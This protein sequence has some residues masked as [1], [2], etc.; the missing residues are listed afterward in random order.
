MKK[1][2]DWERKWEARWIWTR[3]DHRASQPRPF[4]L[5]AAPPLPDRVA[6]LRR[7]FVLERVPV[8]VPCRITS[9]GRYE[10]FVNG[11][12]V[13]RG[14]VRGEPVHLR[15]DE[16]DLAPHLH[17]GDNVIGVV[18]RNYGVP[19]QY[20]RRPQ[21]VGDLGGGGL[22]AEVALEDDLVRTDAAWRGQLAPHEITS[23]GGW[24]G[25]P[26]AE[27][28]DGRRYPWGWNEIGFDDSS[29]EPAVELLPSGLGIHH[30]EPPT[31]PF[32]MLARAP[33]G[34]LAQSIVQ[35][36][37]VVARGRASTDVRAH[38]TAAFTA[39]EAGRLTSEPIT[40][41]LEAGEWLT[42][43]FGKITNSHPRISVAAAAGTVIDLAVGEDLRS[44]GKPEIAPRNWTFRYT[45]AGRDHEE[46]EAFEP[47]GFRYLQIA[48]RE[49]SAS[50]L[51][52]DARFRHFP[53]PSGPFFH[54]DDE[55][56]DTLWSTGA[57]TL[58][59]CSTDAFVDCPGREQRAWV[60]DAYVESLVSLVCN[61]RTDLV[62]WNLELI[63]QG[64][65]PDGLRPAVAGGDFAGLPATLPDFSLHWIRTVA[66]VYEHLGDLGLVERVWPRVLD[67][68]SWFEWHRG[69]D[70]LLT[71]MA[72]WLWVD[73][74]Q[75]E[76]RRNVAAFDAL[77]VLALDD[78]AM[79]ADALR[80]DGT[81][82]RLRGRSQ[83]SQTAFERYWDD[84][85]GVYVDAADPG[86]D[87]G[88]R[89]SQQTNA[90]ALLGCAPRERW[91]D[92]IDYVC[93]EDRLVMTGHPGDGSPPEERLSHHWRQATR[94]RDTL[95]LDEETEVVLAQPFFC[96]FL[97]QSL[98]QAGRHDLL[99][100]SIRRWRRLLD[101]GNGVFEEYW[102]HVPGHG[103][104][105]HA[106]SATPTYDLTR[107]LLGVRPIEPGW[108]AVEIRPWFGPLARLEGSVPTPR[109]PIEIKLDSP[110]GGSVEL[111]EGM[112]GTLALAGQ[113][114]RRLSPGLQTVDAT[115]ER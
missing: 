104:R 19:T 112:H 7:R 108:G 70:G 26:A 74:A 85:R 94:Y 93:D 82:H 51:T 36:V 24:A 60:G 18:V 6:L 39:D 54:C 79:L 5:D 111:P 66:R 56:L 59:A 68:L 89:V 16:Y 38:P 15:W 72:G 44:S 31:D 37:A 46:I 13:G 73:W 65:R 92:M 10:L 12:R 4:Q 17:S 97:H 57:R 78:A 106:W 52:L 23:P 29:W 69:P 90:L 77:Y 81:A 40:S 22:I 49:G 110:G 100:A 103:S 55:L 62:A 84:E 86:G 33:F 107:H 88:R 61:P 96:H 47:V 64:A 45:A 41:T 58:D 101:R 42:V 1:I 63:G 25:P 87:V 75:T 109:G 43:D 2:V 95:A 105:C 35:P 99:L 28:V 8:D 102:D 27:I 9:D 91:A 14:P 80:D 34:Q 32:G 30:A 11:A 114:A 113:Q 20:Y 3:D 71:D 98:A 50:Q 21:S 48:V 67:A 76:R 115:E 83:F 53:R